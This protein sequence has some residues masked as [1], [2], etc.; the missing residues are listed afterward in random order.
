MSN[1]TQ[2]EM[3]IEEYVQQLPTI[4]RVRREYL[5]ICERS[6][7]LEI[8]LEKSL[9]ESKAHDEAMVAVGFELGLKAKAAGPCNCTQN[10]GYSAGPCPI[11]SRKP[12]PDALEDFKA[13]IRESVVEEVASLPWLSGEQSDAI[14]ALIT[15][16]AKGGEG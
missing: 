16:R 12:T 5:A 10:E 1:Q 4:H 8:E 9:T 14:R 11:H 7:M 3:T 6:G 15:E 13:G 2:R